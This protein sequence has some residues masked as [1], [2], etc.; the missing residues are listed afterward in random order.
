[1]A[2]EDSF[3]VLGAFC[4]P[5]VAPQ[6]LVNHSER[7]AKKKKKTVIV[8]GIGLGARMSQLVSFDP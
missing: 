4:F 2:I 3:S 8:I 1:M 7:K 5:M 6:M